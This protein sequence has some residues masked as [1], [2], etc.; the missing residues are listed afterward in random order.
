MRRGVLCKCC[1]TEP[2]KETETNLRTPNRLVKNYWLVAIGWLALAVQSDAQ[3][4][5][6][7]EQCEQHYG[8]PVSAPVKNIDPSVTQYHFKSGKLEL[9]VRISADT[10]QAMAVYYSRLD[11]G[12]FSDSEIKQLL[13]QNGADLNWTTHQEENPASS[14]EKSWIG[15]RAGKTILS[16]SYR[17]L[18]EGEGYVLNIWTGS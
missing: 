1:I 9:Y 13:Q 3:I 8:K 5:W 18:E 10:H 16:A 2:A 17:L 6:S 12:P 7:L 14:D 11:R 15:Q 4:G